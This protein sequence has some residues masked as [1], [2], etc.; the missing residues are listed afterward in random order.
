MRVRSLTGVSG[1][2]PVESEEPPPVPE[3]GWVWC[4]VTASAADLPAVLELT[5]RFG[6]DRLAV[7][8]AVVDVD[9]PKVDDFA[10]HLLIVLHG[11]RSD[12]VAT[13]EVHCLVGERSLV[14]IHDE[15]SPAIDTL[16]SR[17]VQRSELPGST[18]DELVALLADLLT[19]RLVSVLDAFDGQIEELTLRALR[20]DQRL[21]EDLSAIRTDVAAVRRI[22]H[23]QREALDL[24]RRSPFAY[25]GP[26]G[27][28]RFS[29]AFDV[30]NRAAA[31]LEEARS[32]LAETLD[33]YRGAEA[34]QATEITRVLTIY[35]AIMLPLTLITGFFGMNF[36]DL[37]GLDS[38]WGWVL[39]TG[40]M[41]AIAVISLGMFV[42]LGWMSRPSGRRSGRMIG[43]GLLE[44]TRTPIHVLG[45][46]VEMSTI[47]LRATEDLLTRDDERPEGPSDSS[48]H[49]SE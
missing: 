34:R 41:V 17:V 21:L 11:L 40:L 47:P 31:G 4:D 2:R 18:V 36:V 33:A 25:I 3:S 20:A 6:L 46:V 10:D 9:L 35:A 12:R 15:V 19:R 22:V 43:R 23:P 29:D 26:S 14:T 27:R 30:A 45:A 24:L 32:A 48:A 13:Y 37:P 5:D 1:V 49:G 28:R 38:H 7:R 39:T 42:S 44:A 16:W 8:D